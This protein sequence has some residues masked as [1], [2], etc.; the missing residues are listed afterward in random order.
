MIKN[1]NLN[2]FKRWQSQLGNIN[3]WLLIALIFTFTMSMAIGNTLLFLILILWLIEGDFAKKFNKIKNNPV[4]WAAIAFVGLHF[5]GLLWTSD[6][7]GAKFIL[8]KEVEYLMLPILMTVVRPQHIPHYFTALILAML[9]AVGISYGLY[10]D[11]L[12]HYSV[13]RLE[14]S[15]DTT[16]FVSHIVYNPILAFTLYLLLY[17]VFLRKDLSVTLKTIGIVLFIIMGLNMFLT[18]GRMG[19]LVFLVLL[20]LFVFQYYQGQLLKSV[21]LSGLLLMTLAPAAY[22]FSPVVQ[23]RVNQAIHE[24]KH[25]QQEPNSSVGLRVIM[26]LNSIEIIK[27]NPIFGV[28]TGDYQQEYRRVNQQNFP[29]ATRGEELKHSHNVYIQE[30][31][32][33]GILGLGVLLYLFYTMLRHYRQSDSPLKP[34]MLAFPVFYGVIFFTDGYIMDHY[35]SLLFLSLGALLYTEYEQRHG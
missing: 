15:D 11:V 22:L 3:S 21:L 7:E 5:V 26:L 17:A 20:A 25:Y 27:E 24:V 8:K 2:G 29:E 28:G 14:N 6:W 19:Q 4:A 31:V 16:P 1:T 30:M 10:L 23:E 13:L 12:P 33:F 9:I 35:L 32:Q 34:V 18:E